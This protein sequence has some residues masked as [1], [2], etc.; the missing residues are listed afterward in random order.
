MLKFLRMHAVQLV[1]QILGDRAE[2]V[3]VKP[4]SVTLGTPINNSRRIPKKGRN[5][6]EVF[7]LR[8]YTLS[9]HCACFL[10]VVDFIIEPAHVIA[11]RHFQDAFQ[12][13]LQNGDRLPV[14]IIDR[15]G[16]EKQGADGPSKVRNREPGTWTGEWGD[17][18]GRFHHNV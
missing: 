6:P 9:Y 14:D 16:S 1:L 15:R 8:A 2:F 17:S 3:L 12:V 13:R 18:R 10:D 7:A 11:L 5:H 4:H